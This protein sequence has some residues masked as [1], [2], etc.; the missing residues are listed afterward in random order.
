MSD[1]KQELRIQALGS[2]LSRLDWRAT[3]LAYEA[4]RDEFDRSLLVKDAAAEEIDRLRSQLAMMGSALEKCSG[5]IAPLLK[6]SGTPE[7][8]K[9]KFTEEWARLGTLSLE[10]IL[11]EAN[12]ALSTLAQEQKARG[13]DPRYRRLNDGEIILEGDECLTDSHLGWQLETHCIGTPAPDPA[14][15][16]HRIYRRLKEI[17]QEPA[18]QSD[19]NNMAGVAEQSGAGAPETSVRCGA[20]AALAATP[21]SDVQDIRWAVNYLLEQIAGKLSDWP[22]HDIWRSDAADLVRSFKHDLPQAPQSPGGTG[23]VATMREALGVIA[24]TTFSGNEMGDE[25]RRGNEDAHQTCRRLALAALAAHPT[26]K[27][28]GDAAEWQP[29]ETA[30]R[31]GTEVDL[32]CVEKNGKYAPRRLTN[33]RYGSMQNWVG[34]E[35]VSWNVGDPYRDWRPTHWMPLPATPAQ[36][37]RDGASR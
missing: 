23:D 15:T 34:E 1:R 24:R 18:G 13:W 36:S 37:E 11:D 6:L 9:I 8:H 5:A 35:V 27:V 22:T 33:R 25:Y 30:P 14:Y 12:E 26:V 16:S 29:I 32:W 31:D 2:A 3:Q 21:Q 10:Q 28:S 20:P 4:I 17:A 19:A 7:S